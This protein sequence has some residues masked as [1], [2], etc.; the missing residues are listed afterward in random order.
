MFFY[1]L[2]FFASNLASAELSSTQLSY[3]SIINKEIKQLRDECFKRQPNLQKV[4]DPVDPKYSPTE[5][6][7]RYKVLYKISS[8]Q[9]IFDGLLIQTFYTGESYHEWVLEIF[10]GKPFLYFILTCEL[11]CKKV[12]YKALNSL[13]KFI[14]FYYPESINGQNQEHLKHL[15]HY[16]NIE[17]MPSFNDEYHPQTLIL[18]WLRSLQEYLESIFPQENFKDNHQ[19]AQD[20]AILSHKKW[21][22]LQ[23]ELKTVFDLIAAEITE[24]KIDLQN[25][26]LYYKNAHQS[27]LIAKKNRFMQTSKSLSSLIDRCRQI[28]TTRFHY[29]YNG[30]IELV[31]IEKTLEQVINLFNL[32]NKNKKLFF[33]EIFE[34]QQNLY[35]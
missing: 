14:C 2:L 19:F 3:Q 9:D 34:L 26:E 29:E 5:L 7:G 24:C 27:E 4:K 12:K 10:Y 33:E 21:V 25:D 30:R 20:R 6:K 23:Y 13:N 15:I 32:H 17:K 1:F 22:I 18:N 16:I 8:G 28:K 35:A 31:L 11:C